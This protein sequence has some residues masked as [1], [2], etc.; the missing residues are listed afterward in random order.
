M[1]MHMNFN[2]TRKLSPKAQEALRIRAV[3]AV[4]DGKTQKEVAQ[5][6]GVTARSVNTWVKIY[7]A[8]GFEGLK[9]GRQGRPKGGALLPWQAA[10]IARSIKDKMPDQL[11]FPF[12][13]WTR[14]SVALLIEDR[15]D[16]RLS[17]WTVGRYLKRWGYTPQK[18]LKRAYERDPVAVKKWMDEDYPA[19]HKQAR[20]ENALIL[21]GDEMG[22]RSD[23]AVGRTYG[24]RGETPVVK[25][26]GKRFSCNMIS[27]I[28]NMGHLQFMVFDGT[29]DASVFIEFLRRL[30]RSNDRKLF[31]ILDNLK[32]HHSKRA[33]KWLEKHHEQIELFFLPAYSPELNPDERLNQDVKANADK[34]RRARDAEELKNNI[35]GYLRKRQCQPDIV[36]NYF[37]DKAVRYAA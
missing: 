9:T 1:V 32:V 11:H 17:R 15:F 6:F 28:S 29:F 27:A 31:L 13:L 14:E 7:R 23:H 21:W 4:L 10:Q 35:R 3:Q 20:A 2:D 16:I 34:N 22:M 19:I 33:A 25:T 30:I 12:H 26:P 24:K 8:R 5:V 18:P 36:Q 37:E